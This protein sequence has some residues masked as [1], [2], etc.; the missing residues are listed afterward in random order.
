VAFS[1]KTI[2]LTLFTLAALLGAFSLGRM[3]AADSN[4]GPVPGSTDDPLVSRSYVDSRIKS[5]E[6]R[7]AELEKRL[8]SSG[9]T[10]APSQS[11]TTVPAVEQK[12]FSK[13][14]RNWINVRSGPNTNSEIVTQ[15]YPGT[16]M[17]LLEIQGDWYKVRMPDGT[18]GFVSNTV[19]EIR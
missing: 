5:L 19:A 10:V 17:A 14:G 8:G 16:A 7:V 6:D 12:V 1:R 15:C 4:S 9:S 18:V 13:S 2:I 11:G 3:V